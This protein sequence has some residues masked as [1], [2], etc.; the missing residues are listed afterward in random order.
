MQIN[1]QAYTNCPDNLPAIRLLLRAE[2]SAA[3]PDKKLE[4]I[5]ETRVVE[6]DRILVTVTAEYEEE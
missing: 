2:L 6:D 4:N 5:K 3:V 1:A